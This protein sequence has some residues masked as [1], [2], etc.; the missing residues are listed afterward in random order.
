VHAEHQKNG[1][2]YDV[3]TVNG[4]KAFDVLADANYGIVF[5]STEDKADEDNKRDKKD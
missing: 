5:S 1:W 3:G 2:A 4:D